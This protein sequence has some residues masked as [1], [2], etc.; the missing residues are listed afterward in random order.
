MYVTA[1][2]A[3]GSSLPFT[4]VCMCMCMHVCSSHFSLLQTISCTPV[5]CKHRHEYLD[6]IHEPYTVMGH[7]GVDFESHATTNHVCTC[8]YGQ[9]GVYYP[10]VSIKHLVTSSPSFTPSLT[11]SLFLSLLFSLSPSSVTPDQWTSF[12]N[13][14]ILK[15]ERECN[16]SMTLRGVASG[17]LEQTLQDLEQQRAQVDLALEKRIRE[18]S[19]AKQSLEQHLQ[20][21][22]SR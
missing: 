10:P 15:T 22:G 3:H 8:P 11:S 18:T 20:K 5:L 2:H 19:E 13:E 4:C 6:K 17:V 12:S 7:Q 9:E 16:A 14:N 1:L 21:V